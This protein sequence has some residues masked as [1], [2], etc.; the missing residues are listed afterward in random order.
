MRLRAWGLHFDQMGHLEPAPQPTAPTLLDSFLDDARDW[1][2]GRMW[3]PRALLLFFLVYIFTVK[4]RDPTRWTIFYGITLA[5]HEMG[6]LVFAWAP[7]FITSIMGSVFQIARQPDYFGMSV[8]GFWLSY[9]LYELSAYVGDARSKDLPLVGFASSEDLE[10][11]WAYLLGTMHM[12]P[13]DHAFAFLLRMAGLLAGVGSC[14]FAV[15]LL[16]TM[17][18]SR[19]ARG[20]E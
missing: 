6:H 12:L 20:F 3:I 17:A 9:S 18:R 13:L 2:R 1:C 19:N 5:F 10:H 16:I 14:A 4:F 7:H 11:D 15:W 8:G